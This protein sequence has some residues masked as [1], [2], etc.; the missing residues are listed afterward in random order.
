MSRKHRRISRWIRALLA[1]VALGLGW[2]AAAR[3]AFDFKDESW[4]GSSELLRIARTSLGRNRVRV[5][6]VVP[7][8]ELRP[9]DAL[10]VVHPERALDYREAAAFLAAGGRVA[11]LDDF[12]KGDALLER[13][14]IRRVRAPL[15]PTDALRSNAALPI[16]VPRVDPEAS[17]HPILRGVRQVVT[18]HPTALETEKGLQL[19]TILE[20]RSSDEPPLPF[21]LIGVIGDARRCGLVS[22]VAENA[23]AAA[24]TSGTCG[25]L[26]A[27]GDASVLMNQML[28]YPGNRTLAERLIEYLLGDDSWGKRGGILYLVANEFTERG[29][30][31]SGGGLAGAIED[32]IDGLSQW[33]DSVRREGLPASLAWFLAGCVGLAVGVWT[34]RSATKRYRRVLPRYTRETPPVAQGGLSGRAALLAAPSTHPALS[35][36]ELKSGL[37]EVLRD[38][39]GLAATASREA[40]LEEIDRQGALGRRNSE[41][42]VSLFEQMSR[43]ELAVAQA[44]PIRIP[45][46]AIQ[47]MHEE[48]SAILAEIEER[49]GK[50]S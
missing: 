8:D 2:P 4:E 18:N 7:W 44:K 45:E 41:L 30:Y 20:F 50:R 49:T 46:A 5:T 43:S 37:E 35:V 40:I 26:L 32:R 42:L 11:L 19:T 17:A 31:G 47:R 15:S 25:R 10:L 22:D 48:M 38:R 3:A 23:P 13:F 28:R 6:P 27:M 33:V 36:L 1:S 21:A 39:L 12:G 29:S 14:R 9:S 16:A 34:A 24:V